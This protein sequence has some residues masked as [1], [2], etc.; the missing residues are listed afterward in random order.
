[1]LLRDFKMIT[2]LVK[3]SLTV[4][5]F[6]ILLVGSTILGGGA[7]NIA[8]AQLMGEINGHGDLGSNEIICEPVTTITGPLT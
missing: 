7:V 6:L 2:P 4:C 3:R 1:M 5:S 8:N